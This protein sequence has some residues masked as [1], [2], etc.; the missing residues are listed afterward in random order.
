LGQHY[1]VLDGLRTNRYLAGRFE[2]LKDGYVD[3]LY[4]GIRE[5]WVSRQ[6]T[7]KIHRIEKAT[8]EIGDIRDT[9]LQWKTAQ[10]VGPENKII[11][12]QGVGPDDR[13]RVQEVEKNI[14]ESLPHEASHVF[15]RWLPRWASEAFAEHMNLVVRNGEPQIV[16]PTSRTHDRSDFYAGERVLLHGACYFSPAGHAAGGEAVMAFM[17]G[18]TS[19]NA[20]SAEW[21][22]FENTLDQMWGTPGAFRKITARV[23]VQ[24][25]MVKRLHP[26]WNNWRVERE[27]AILVKNELDEEPGNVFGSDYKKPQPHVGAAALVGSVR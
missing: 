24:E 27:A 18:A 2:S 7:N 14:Y 12:A 1:A 20:D 3:R 11:M 15:G 25:E 10:Y 8:L 19:R 26:D 22:M 17:R 23:D 9:V 5:G 6:A 4:D 21:R 16:N 13:H